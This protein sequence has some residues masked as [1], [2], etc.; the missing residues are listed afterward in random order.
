MEVQCLL[1]LLAAG[2]FLWAQPV[3]GQVWRQALQI[4]LKIREAVGFEQGL[5]QTISRHPSWI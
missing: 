5:D 4:T 1:P 3:L 2:R